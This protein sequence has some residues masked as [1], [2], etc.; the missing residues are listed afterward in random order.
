[1]DVYGRNRSYLG[2][3]WTMSSPDF[4]TEEIGIVDGDPGKEAW[5]GMDLSTSAGVA[6]RYDWKNA[7]LVFGADYVNLLQSQKMDVYG[8]RVRSYNSAGL[9]L[10]VAA[11]DPHSVGLDYKVGLEYRYSDDLANDQVNGQ[12]GLR[13]HDLDFG[14]NVESVLSGGHN[15]KI[16]A[17]F[18]MTD[19]SGA[20]DVTAGAL[21]FA[22]RYV[23]K[24]SRWHFDMGLRLST[25][26]RTDGKSFVYR[27]KEQV[28]YPDIRAEY[29]VS[30]E[31]LKVYASLGGGCEMNTY[32]SLVR[33]NRRLNFYYGRG[34]WDI[35]D[36]TEERL[37]A[38]L[39]F[40][41]RI[42]HRFGYTLKGG[43]KI[44]GNAPLQALYIPSTGSGYLPALGYAPYQIAYASMDFLFDSEP[45]RIDGNLE[46]NGVTSIVE[47]FTTLAGFVFPAPFKGDVEVMYDFKDRI[48][49][50]VDC[51]FSTSRDG[52]AYR[53][54]KVGSAKD[55]KVTVPGYADLGVS[56]EYRFN[57]KMSLWARG[58]NLLGMKI[59]RE[60]LYAEKGPYFTAGICLNL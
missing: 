29:M 43:Y 51:E 41:G 54:T 28:I 4:T 20:F 10:G 2:N 36:V 57:N 23:L 44:Y 6:G 34:V 13:S 16:D 45:L 39:G 5:S 59:Q 14:L 58:G 33:D 37:A 40:E 48:F 38:E 7:M 53:Q 52:R 22:P 42:T 19:E 24:A 47:S 60:L 18:S 55:Y 12:A 50:G 21:E 8:L 11:K 27:Y 26:F 1:L 3:Y 32:A 49:A 56:L 31:F 17:K 30:P 46:F 35:L 15:M 25:V 9:N